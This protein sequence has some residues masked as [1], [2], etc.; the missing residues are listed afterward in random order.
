MTKQQQQQFDELQLK[1]KESNFKISYVT[2]PKNPRGHRERFIIDFDGGG[3][4]YGLYDFE[5]FV[6]RV[7]VFLH[8]YNLDKEELSK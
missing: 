5:I 6:K 3:E 1:C 8:L 2:T 7:Q 4:T